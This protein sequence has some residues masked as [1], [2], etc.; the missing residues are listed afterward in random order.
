M[1]LRTVSIDLSEQAK[2]TFAG[3]FSSD[4]YSSSAQ[5]LLSVFDIFYTLFARYDRLIEFDLLNVQGVQT[6]SQG[7]V[8]DTT[9]GHPAAAAIVTLLF[10]SSAIISTYFHL[11]YLR[12]IKNNHSTHFIKEELEAAIKAEQAKS[13]LPVH[14]INYYLALIVE[15]NPDLK[16]KYH[17]VKL[18]GAGLKMSYKLPAVAQTAEP[19]VEVVHNVGA[20]GAGAGAEIEVK[21]PKLSRF[22]KFS[23]TVV[24]PAWQALNLSAFTYWIMWIGT[25]LF[26]GKFDLGISG[27][28]PWVAFGIPIAVGLAYPVIKTINYFRHRS[29]AVVE[30][31]AATPEDKKN[32]TELIRRAM[33]RRLFELEKAALK[34]QLDAHKFVDE[35]EPVQAVDAPLTNKLD[36]K[37]STLG[38]GRWKKTAVTLIATAAATFVGLQYGTWL[39]SDILTTVANITIGAPIVQLVLGSL[40]MAAAGIYGIYKAVER[41]NQVNDHAANP[42]L[43]AT[44]QQQLELSQ[45]ENRLEAS[46]RNIALLEKQLGETSTKLPHYQEE[47]FFSDI[48]RRGASSWTNVKKFATRSVYFIN[49]CLTGIF[50]A[51]LFFIKGTALALPFAAA[52]FSNPVTIGILVGAG[53]V[54][55]AFKVYQYHQRRKEEGAELLFSQ[56]AERVECLKQEVIIAGMRE[57]LYTARVAQQNLAAAAAPTLPAEPVLTNAGA[58]LLF[59]PRSYSEGA[60]PPKNSEPISVPRASRNTPGNVT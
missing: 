14:D 40:V 21:K 29:A 42:Q 43:S 30:E 9:A 46:Q 13:L 7:F 56:R 33:L 41:F 26:T 38:K 54:Y 4:N 32:G 48:S 24:S 16:D 18:D 39:I 45:L 58:V 37:I 1:N 22:Q 57:R 12:K 34:V 47:Q 17:E 50:L 23:R 51:R 52:T 6:Q 31:S 11:N 59:R 8:I 10:A 27:V 2:Q 28:S 19:E 49:G 25:G 3:G 20:Q 35:P 5:N 36:S 60:T 55:G 15:D 53:L 44:A